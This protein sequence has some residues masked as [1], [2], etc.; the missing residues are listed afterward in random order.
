MHKVYR[1]GKL[2]Y[3][4]LWGKGAGSRVI[5]CGREK[6]FGRAFLAKAVLLMWQSVVDAAA[7][8]SDGPV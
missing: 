3:P 8:C 7:S 2:S 6:Y 5:D 1:R 4:P